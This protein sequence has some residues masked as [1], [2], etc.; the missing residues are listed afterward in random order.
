MVRILWKTVIIGLLLLSGLAR[1]E[2]DL[3]DRTAQR[4]GLSAEL[5]R[6]IALVESRMYP[7]AVNINWESFHPPTPWQAVQLIE[8]AQK[9]PWLLKVFYKNNNHRLFFQSGK[10]AQL[11]LQNLLAR[12]KFLDTEIPQ[13]WEIRRLDVRSVD[14][15]LMQIN[16]KFHGEHFAS[17]QELFD[18]ATN[19]DYAARFLK[20][21]L[22]QHGDLEKAVAHYHSST[23]EFQIRYLQAFRQ[24]YEKQLLAARPG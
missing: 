11:A 18:P 23:E 6:S 16:W 4:H 2:G 8:Q 15:G 5:L 20:S 13:Q 22:D 3:F 17:M 19:L 7:W 9:R 14:I 21:L 10:D 12:A 24:V 1:A